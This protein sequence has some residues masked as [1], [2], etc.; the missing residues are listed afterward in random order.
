MS[1][2]D[3]QV[4]DIL[5]LEPGDIICADGIFIEGHNLKCDESA[6]TGESDTVRKL[7]WQECYNSSKR[8][9]TETITNSF[10]STAVSDLDERSPDPFLISGSKVVEGIC[11][12]LVT[13][14]GP[15]SF[16]GRTLMSLR[17]KDENTPL[18]DKLD[19]LATSIAKFGLLAAG[20]LLTMLGIRSIVGYAN[21]SLSTVPSDIVSHV[22]QILITT[23]TVI[24]VAV[25]EGLPLA[26]TLG[27]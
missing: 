12:Y 25:P 27:K 20:F 13:A 4:G 17:T 18:Q 19:V 6:A 21:G 22:M 26:V 8:N 3:V 11:T 14:V 7:C 2:T 24:V 16:H 15:N 23:V 1:I 9:S 5:K 10:E